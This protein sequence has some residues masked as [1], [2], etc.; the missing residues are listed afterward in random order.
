MIQLHSKK[1]EVVTTSAIGPKTYYL[2][3]FCLGL[4][5]NERNETGGRPKSPL[6]DPS[7]GMPRITCCCRSKQVCCRRCGG[8]PHT[9]RSRPDTPC[10]PNRSSLCSL[11][12]VT[13][14]G[15]ESSYGSVHTKR[16]Q[17]SSLLAFVGICLII[18][19]KWPPLS[20][21]LLFS[22]AIVQCE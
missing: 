2:A 12:S 19:N 17:L 9:L 21:R 22:F 8:L 6:S 1:E 16:L 3:R 7:I 14:F 15:H 4:H 13:P 5:E 20:H 18:I 10:W 11:W